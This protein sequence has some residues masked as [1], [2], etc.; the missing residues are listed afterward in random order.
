ME[1]G[2]ELRAGPRPHPAAIFA[3]RVIANVE[4]AILDRPMTPLEVQ[5][6][7]GVG[8]IARQTRDAIDHFVRPLRFA[9]EAISLSDVSGEA[10]DLSNA[11][12]AELLREVEIQRGG[13]LQRAPFFATVLFADGRGALLLCPTL[14]LLVGGKTRLLRP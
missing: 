3:K 4:N 12:P 8:L 11:R 1:A 5:E 7:P 14:P 6:F 2:E 13:A 10:K 9:R